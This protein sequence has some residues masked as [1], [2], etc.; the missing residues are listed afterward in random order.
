MGRNTR[1][2]TTAPHACAMTCAIIVAWLVL[3]VIAGES[4]VLLNLTNA[5][6]CERGPVEQST[7]RTPGVQLWFVSHIKQ[8]QTYS[9]SGADGW[10]MMYTPN[11]LEGKF[12]G[13]D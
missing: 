8:S 3:L 4:F 5:L 9:I 1:G 12:C 2:D 11:E 7:P 10:F 13:R 6:R